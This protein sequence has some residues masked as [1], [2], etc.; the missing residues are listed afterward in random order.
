MID[1]TQPS[2]AE[3]QVLLQ[4]PTDKTNCL[5]LAQG[6]ALAAALQQV[7]SSMTKI[8]EKMDALGASWQ[9]LSQKTSTRQSRR[10]QRSPSSDSSSTSSSSGSERRPAKKCKRSNSDMRRQDSPGEAD[11]AENLLKA[12]SNDQP[13]SGIAAG[14]SP[15]A[16]AHDALLNDIANEFDNEDDSISTPVSSQ[17]A[18]IVNKRWSE[19]MTD[20]KQGKYE[21]YGRPSNCEKL[22][23]PK[24]NPEIW[25]QNKPR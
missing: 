4:Q 21:K 16:P 25:G 22:T 11:D 24:V 9:T 19:K 18:D 7:S 14:D 23:V 13:A 10:R 1:N 15:C 3:T 2:E 12:H 5:S 8:N 20:K 17:L 6:D